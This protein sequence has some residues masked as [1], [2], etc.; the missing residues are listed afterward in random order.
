ML[1]KKGI[2]VLDGDSQNMLSQ[3]NRRQEVVKSSLTRTVTLVNKF[4]PAVEEFSLLNF[5]QEELSQINHKFDEIQGEIELLMKSRM[6]PKRK[7]K[8]LKQ[9]ITKYDPEYKS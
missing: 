6:M 7:E 2:I 5:R 8:N 4:N 1:K 3:L 9:N